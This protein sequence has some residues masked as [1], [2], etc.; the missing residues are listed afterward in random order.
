[1]ARKAA[2]QLQITINSNDDALTEAS[3]ALTVQGMAMQKIMSAYNIRTTNKDVLVAEIRGHIESASELMFGMGARLMLLKQQC[4]HGEWLPTLEQIG[5]ASRTAAQLMQ[6][7]VK[8]SD[9]HTGRARQQ[10]VDLDKGKLLELVLLDDEQID[11]L[12][13]GEMLELELDEV[14]RMST[15][16][17]RRKVRELKMS[18]DSKDKLLEKRG[19][20]MDRLQQLADGVFIPAPGSV[21]Q[22]Q[23]EQAAYLELEKVHL[24][25]N[26]AL[27]RLVVV[28][29]DIKHETDSEAMTMAADNAVRHL[30]QRMA[31]LTATH[32]IAVDFEEMV[33][34]EWLAG[35]VTAQTKKK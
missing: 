4:A 29:H 6:A 25:A 12:D 8:F 30:C 23:L 27:A 13:K 32:G 21:A 31:D 16:Q 20:E 1:M 17:L 24:E 28:V 26:A 19:K 5:V 7:T 34:P 14:S 33:T 15:T 18:A 9:P 2:T 3:Q 22:T 11:A 35:A 10:F